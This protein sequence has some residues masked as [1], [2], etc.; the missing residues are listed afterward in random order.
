[1]GAD[2]GG[3]P[4]EGAREELDGEGGGEVAAGD[5]A[6]GGDGG[7]ADAVR[8][9]GGA[10]GDED[11]DEEE[12]VAGEV[13]REHLGARARRAER[14]AVRKRP[15]LVGEG[16]EHDRL[17]AADRWGLGVESLGDDAL[18][19]GLWEVEV[20]L[21]QALGLGQLLGPLGLLFGVDED[22]FAAAAQGRDSGADP[23]PP[24]CITARF[25]VRR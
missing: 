12:R 20:D 1:M 13:G 22:R 11:V 25:L 21:A 10:E 24:W 4:V 17:P 19:A 5:G 8:G 23:R 9:D 2:G 18:R 3:D 7:V 16:Q 15:E 14:E 6:E